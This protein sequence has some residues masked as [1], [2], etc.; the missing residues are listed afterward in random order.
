M[1][2]V[3]LHSQTLEWIKNQVPCLDDLYDQVLSLAPDFISSRFPP[4][5]PVP[6]AVPCFHDTLH[7]LAQARYALLEAHS[8]G[9]SYRNKGGWKDEMTAVWMERFYVDDVAFRLYSAGEHLANAIIC[10]ME[11]SHSDL[12]PFKSKNISTQ[13]AVGQYLLKKKPLLPVA[14]AIA[15]LARSSAWAEAIEYRNELV[16]E[17]PPSVHGLGIVYK[18]S[19]RW[20]R[21]PDGNTFELSIGAGDKPDFDTQQVIKLMTTALELLIGALKACLAYYEDRLRQAGFTSSQRA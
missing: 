15:S 10:M 19:K 3:S 11:I 8:H 12:L 7:T 5:S 18:R 1:T 9:I 14:Q 20:Q 21:S 2:N 4:A 16:H 17:Q 6:V 13:A